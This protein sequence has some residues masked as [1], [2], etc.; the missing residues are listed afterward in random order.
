MACH[1]EDPKDSTKA[2]TLLPNGLA[3][4]LNKRIV[5]RLGWPGL[6]GLIGQSAGKAFGLRPCAT[7]N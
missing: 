5:S 3:V 7:R 2:R 1:T 4:K 6:L